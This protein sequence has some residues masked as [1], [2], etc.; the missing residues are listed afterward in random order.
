MIKVSEF[1][2]EYLCGLYQKVK[3]MTIQPELYERFDIKR[4]L[5]NKDGS[6]VLAGI[7]NVCGVH[8]YVVSESEK[9]AVPGELTYRGYDINDLTQ[10]AVQENRFGFEET[11]F[12][13]LFGKLPSKEEYDRFFDL[14]NELK[15]LP[16]TFVD[17]M[18]IKAPSNN[19]MNKLARSILA[20]YSYDDDVEDACLEKELLIALTLIAR[21]P[22][23]MV[24]AYQVKRRH[25][26]NESMFIHPTGEKDNIAQRILSLLRY[27]R[28]FTEQE[29]RLLDLCLMLHA[30]HGAGNNSTFTCRVV[31][32]SGTDA[33]SAY[34]AAIGSLKG[35][36]HGGANIKVN[37]MI[38]QIK[39]AID[40]IT[41]EEQVWD[42]LKRILGKEVGDGSGL[43]YGMGHAVYTISDPRAIILRE[44]AKKLA[45]GSEYE[46][47]FKLLMLIEKLAPD[48]YVAVKGGTKDM[49]ANVD[50]YSGLVYKM[51]KV[52]SDLFT[53]LFAVSRIA[54]WAA[55]RIE[56]LTTCNRIIRPAYKTNTKKKEYIAV[57]NRN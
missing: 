41:D 11:V 16:E 50:L 29:A 31:T 44:N 43:I 36:K 30:D 17:D 7:S 35:P 10:G 12:L 19:I 28:Q 23:I 34:A 14:L 8:G 13:L 56:E 20:L 52:P 57:E 55:H 18:I 37:E 39:A 45:M 1:D 32:S 9:T 3:S 49:C 6:G 2:N 27:D 26:D 54:G 33:Y 25:Y 15:D 40:D 47:E 42:V 5:R 4:G 21:L 22:R 48:V 51:L 24:S 46:A 38:E 53:P